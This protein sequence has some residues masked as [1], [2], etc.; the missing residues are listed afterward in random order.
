MRRLRGIGQGNRIGKRLM[1]MIIV[2]SSLIT[3]LT[4]AV[5]LLLDYRQQRKAMDSVLDTAAVYV[6]IIADSVWALDKTQIELALGALVQMPNIELAQ[7]LASDQKREWKAGKGSSTNIVTREFALERKVRGRMEKIATLQVVASLDAIYRSVFEHAISILLSN[8]LKTFFVAIFMFIIF[9]RV[10]TERLEAL[11]HKAHALPPQMF[12]APFAA[13]VATPDFQNGNDEIDS[14][15]HAFDAM[16]ERLRAAIEALQQH[17][18]K[19]EE[20]IKARTGELVEQKERLAIALEERTSSNEELTRTL[21]VLRDT[22]EEFINREKLA[23]LGALVAGV[24]HE[25]NTPIGNGLTS[26]STLRDLTNDMQRK[27]S[28]GL[29]R[30][31]LESYLQAAGTASDIVIRNLQRSAQLVNGFKQVAVDQTTSQRRDFALRTVVD[32]IALTLQPSLSK[33]PYLLSSSIDD[34]IEMD[35]YPGPLGQ[36]LTNLIN[37]AIL[38]GFDGRDCGVIAITGRLVGGD[39]VELVVKDDGR[40]IPPAH[41]NHVFDPFF[42]T[43][44]GRGGTGLG[45]NI[46]HGIVTGVLG[47]KISVNTELGQGTAFTVLMPLRAPANIS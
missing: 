23:A 42:T 29:K 21:E 9:R 12:P 32:E 40:G 37:N 22:Q 20:V 30:S 11:A 7:V 26:A 17:Q 14:V 18:A 27:L 15:S 6:P 5:Q 38:H 36:V 35:S 47:G 31:T 28:E 8:A 19:L 41:L 10:V 2:F 13:E 45:L 33:L 4:T 43:K 24:A 25:L 34:G 16:S 46:V 44:L 39:R 3:L 1:V